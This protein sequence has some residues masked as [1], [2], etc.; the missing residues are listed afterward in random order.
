MARIHIRRFD[1]QGGKSI[2][3][4]EQAIYGASNSLFQKVVDS[5]ISSKQPNITG[6]YYELKGSDWSDTFDKT[7]YFEISEEEDLK[8]LTNVDL[9]YFSE[10]DFFLVKDNFEEYLNELDVDIKLKT[11]DKLVFKTK[12]EADSFLD[13]FQKKSC[14]P[15]TIERFYSIEYLK[16]F[17]ENF[18]FMYVHYD[19]DVHTDTAVY[20]G[21]DRIRIKLYRK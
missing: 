17:A 8:D 5:W 6:T 12:E 2:A 10:N 16:D 21:F 15:A 13:S 9:E 4:A 18:G 19:D 20:R 3:M 7:H 14:N 11:L 1:D